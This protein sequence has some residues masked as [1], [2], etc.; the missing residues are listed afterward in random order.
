MAVSLVPLSPERLTDL[1]R[2]LCDVFQ[3]PPEAGFI[4]PPLLQWKYFAP[5]PYSSG[6]RS[7]V[8]DVDGVLGAHG[9][10]TPVRYQVSEE[11]VAAMQIIDWAAGHSC[12]A[13]G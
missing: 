3:L 11:V 12:P 1:R 9:C 10:V 8:L 7:Y 6:P 4:D 2:F 5:H 13:A